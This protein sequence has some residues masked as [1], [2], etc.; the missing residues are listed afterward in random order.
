M[1][2]AFVAALLFDTGG[3]LVL[4]GPDCGRFEA[5]VGL[6]S[7]EV[8]LDPSDETRARTTTSLIASTIMPLRDPEQL[9]RLGHPCAGDILRQVSKVSTDQLL[10]VLTE[11]EGSYA[12]AVEKRMALIKRERLSVSRDAEI[13]LLLLG[14]GLAAPSRFER[15]RDGHLL[16]PTI[17]DLAG[18]CLPWRNDAEIIVRSITKAAT[19]L[20]QLDA[21][22]SLPVDWSVPDSPKCKGRPLPRARAIRW[23]IAQVVSRPDVRTWNPKEIARLIVAARRLRQSLAPV[24]AGLVEHIVDALGPMG[25]RRAFGL[26]G[27]GP[28]SDDPSGRRLS[29]FEMEDALYDSEWEAAHPRPASTAPA[30]EWNLWNRGRVSYSKKRWIETDLFAPSPDLSAIEVELQLLEKR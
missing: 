18:D 22:L 30:S 25:Y 29:H 19:K 2:S 24:A 14:Q 20:D 12:S 5:R 26:I 28:I 13:Q 10:P 16:L 21:A 7:L 23:G 1:I 8:Y 4:S 6:A 15:L 9:R 27:L 11:L 3:H 17:D